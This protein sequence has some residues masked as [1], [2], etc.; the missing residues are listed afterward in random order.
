M[1]G[2]IIVVGPAGWVERREELPSQLRG[3]VY[4]FFRRWWNG[5]TYFHRDGAKYEVARVSPPRPLG[6]V[7]RIL[8]ASIYNPSLDFTVEHR[9]TGTWSIDELRGALRVAI[10]RDDD[11]LTQFHERETLLARLA[12]AKSFDDVVNVIALAETPA[13]EGLDED[14]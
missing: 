5:T 8:A 4:G 12:M 11:I 13:D 9:R 6:S 7:H 2:N 14:G 10:E 3:S 1:S